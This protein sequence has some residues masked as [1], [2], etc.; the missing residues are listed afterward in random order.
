MRLE[1]TS[2]EVNVMGER[3]RYDV[4]L[5]KRDMGQR[6][7]ED[8]MNVE[9]VKRCQKRDVIFFSFSRACRIIWGRRN[10]QNKADGTHDE[11]TKRWIEVQRSLTL[12]E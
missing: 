4:G 12:M 9:T 1:N 3:R 6:K 7:D 11:G 5:S 10:G 2:S 8:R